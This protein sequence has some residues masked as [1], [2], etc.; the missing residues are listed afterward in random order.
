MTSTR[1]GGEPEYLGDAVYAHFD[2]YHVV[3]TANDRE[4]IIY[5]DPGVYAA[6]QVFATRCWGP[7]Q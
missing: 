4:Q 2:G 1:V 7:G 5:L 3:L 6:L